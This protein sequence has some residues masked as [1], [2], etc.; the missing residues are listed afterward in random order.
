M[1]VVN[2]Q[3]DGFEEIQAAEKAV[4]VAAVT[5]DAARDRLCEA[6]EA[7]RQAQNNLVKVQEEHGVPVPEWPEHS[8][9]GHRWWAAEVSDE[10]PE[11]IK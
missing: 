11:R 3:L 9:I 8:M 10:R 7:L 1:S 5:M 2:R 4:D 6:A